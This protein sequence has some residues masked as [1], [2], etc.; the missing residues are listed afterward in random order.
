MPERPYTIEQPFADPQGRLKT[1]TGPLKFIRRLVHL[2]YVFFFH[3][4]VHGVYDRSYGG[5]EPAGFWERVLYVFQDNGPTYIK[6]GQLLS[7]RPELP[8]GLTNQLEKLLDEGAPLST[9]LIK[10]RVENQ[11]GPIE[12]N[13]KEFDDNPIATASLAQVHEAK[14][15]SGERVAVKIRK[16]GLVDR[17][18]VD[19]DILRFFGTALSKLPAGIFKPLPVNPKFFGE[20]VTTFEAALR[21]EVDFSKEGEFIEK[22]N[23]IFKYNEDILT[24]EVYWDYTSESV[25]VME[26]MEGLQLNEL[27]DWEA[28]GIDPRKVST[29]ATQAAMESFLSGMIHGDPHPANIMGTKDGKVVLL[30]FGMSIEMSDEEID[31]I[32]KA[33]AAIAKGDIDELVDLFFEEMAIIPEYENKQEIIDRALSFY[34]EY[35]VQEDEGGVPSIADSAWQE[36]G[37]AR[38]TALDDLLYLGYEYDVFVKHQYILSLKSLLYWIK[39]GEN[40]WPG[41]PLFEMIIPYAQAFYR[42]RKKDP[43]TE[44]VYID[45]ESALRQ[46]VPIAKAMENALFKREGIEQITELSDK[47]LNL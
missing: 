36:E 39:T 23:E 15:N 12:K 40:L 21:K 42:N 33:I 43:E 38:K 2:I 29:H 5:E 26:F 19:L 25:L 9:S 7:Q 22:F 31:I 6:F 37:D 20:F 30:D 32:L 34:H 18:N 24:P 41:S 13:F 27:E 3:I 10:E 28:A 46:A 16:T 45:R 47:D 1:P 11:I 35:I 4:L 14:L 44:K 17:I 8:A